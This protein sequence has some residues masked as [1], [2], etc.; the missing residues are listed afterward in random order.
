MRLRE[1]VN[2][3]CMNRENGK[4]KISIAVIDIIDA[5]METGRLKLLFILSGTSIISIS[6]IIIIARTEAYMRCT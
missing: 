3:L 1:F 2:R 5:R 6:I 4:W